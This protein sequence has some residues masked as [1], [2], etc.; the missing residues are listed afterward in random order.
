MGL[1]RRP[2]RAGRHGAPRG[3]LLL[4][5]TSAIASVVAL[6][7]LLPLFGASLLLVVLLDQLVVCR[8][9]T[10]AGDSTSRQPAPIPL[11]QSPLRRRSDASPSGLA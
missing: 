7:L 1:R 11:G 3:R 2:K 5:A 4:D 10:L 8:S 9:A 6:G